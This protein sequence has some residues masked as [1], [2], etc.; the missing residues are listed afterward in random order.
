MVLAGSMCGFQ[1]QLIGKSAG[2]DSPLGMQP[3]WVPGV[4]M[5]KYGTLA[6]EVP[7]CNATVFKAQQA[8]AAA[9]LGRKLKY[10][11]NQQPLNA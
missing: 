8:A 11:I 5:S 3:C 7:D 4:P 1:A 2:G 6:H 10:I 9:L